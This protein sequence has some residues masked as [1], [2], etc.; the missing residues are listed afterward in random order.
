MGGDLVVWGTSCSTV[1]L[2]WSRLWPGGHVQGNHVEPGEGTSW[3]AGAGPR[4]QGEGHC[5]LCP[6]TETN[7]QTP[8]LS[9]RG[10]RKGTDQGASARGAGLDPR[11]HW[12]YSLWCQPPFKPSLLLPVTWASEP[13]ASASTPV[14][15]G[16]SRG[17]S[18]RQH[19]GPDWRLT[20]HSPLA[21]P[22][23]R[24]PVAHWPPSLA[25]LLLEPNPALKRWWCRRSWRTHGLPSARDAPCF[26]PILF[27]GH[28]PRQWQ[29]VDPGCSAVSELLSGSPA[30]ALPEP[31]VLGTLLLGSKR[32][33]QSPAGWHHSWVP[34]CPQ[35]PGHSAAW[36][37]LGHQGHQAPPCCV[38][39]GV[40]V[41]LCVR[42]WERVL[43][44]EAGQ[45]LCA[46]R[47]GA[48]RPGLN[49]AGLQHPAGVTQAGRA[50]WLFV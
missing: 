11:S 1:L 20:R 36:T 42:R 41:R 28:A 22:A 39:A 48:S 2:S 37:L 16:T 3:T 4:V 46:G 5:S 12:S 34:A 35:A 27:P 7:Q 25:I 14:N 8:L 9:E 10:W 30:T 32:W 15:S 43:S 45:V 29:D 19:A 31:C 21:L 49:R 50:M 24:P 23:T 47:E 17:S 40:S 6:W 33:G 13:L 38:C 44:R 18:E 26:L